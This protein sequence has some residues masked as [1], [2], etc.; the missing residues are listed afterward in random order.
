MKN[1]SCLFFFYN[2]ATLRSLAEDSEFNEP[3]QKQNSRGSICPRDITR[4]MV[5]FSNRS[6]KTFCS[7]SVLR[8]ISKEVIS[9]TRVFSK[10]VAFWVFLSFSTLRMNECSRKILL[11]L[12]NVNSFFWIKSVYI[13]V[14]NVILNIQEKF[15][16][17]RWRFVRVMISTNLKNVVLRNTSLKF[18][19]VKN[20]DKMHTRLIADACTIDL[21]GW[22]KWSILGFWSI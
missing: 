6:F 20:I 4:P 12:L 16:V 15:Q 11:F 5:K 2:M 7:K 22:F 19:V 18:S 9:Q 21:F 14:K 8:F 13:S 3:S 17:S 1:V 10:S